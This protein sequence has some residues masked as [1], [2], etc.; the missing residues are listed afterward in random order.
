MVLDRTEE[1]AEAFRFW[2][3]DKERTEH[4]YVGVYAS[5]SRDIKS[6][7]EIGID[8][9]S[10]LLAWCDIFPKASIWGIDPA[11][12][13]V[14]PEVYKRDQILVVFSDFKFFK[15]SNNFDLIVDDGSHRTEDMIEAWLQFGSLLSAN[16][17]YVIEDIE[18]SQVEELLRHVPGQIIETPG[19]PRYT[20]SR[21]LMV[22]K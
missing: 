20:D 17:V 6:I 9:G 18:K 14:R 8:R 11:W 12:E 21:V 15:S 16:G 1:V 13:R 3:T 22:R 10:S 4:N 2:Q 5:I 19:H 7:L